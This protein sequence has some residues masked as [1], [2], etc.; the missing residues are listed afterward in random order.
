MPIRM[1]ARELYR[2]QQKVDLLEKEL[3][4]AHPGDHDAIREKLRT[5]RAEWQQ[6]RHI[7]DGE[8]IRPER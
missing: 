8:K 7:L 2:A 3:A 5:A 1:I 6:I 4:A